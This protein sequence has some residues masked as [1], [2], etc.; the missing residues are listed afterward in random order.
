MGS[1]PEKKEKNLVTL[2]SLAKPHSTVLL[3]KEKKKIQV[4]VIIILLPVTPTIFQMS[5]QHLM[6]AMLYQDQ[7]TDLNPSIHI[8]VLD[9]DPD[10]SYMRYCISQYLIRIHVK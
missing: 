9:P 10:S 2:C 3:E 8:S 7:L 5:V 6:P 1:I 4:F